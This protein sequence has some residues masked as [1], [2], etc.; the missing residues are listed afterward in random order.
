MIINN[1]FRYVLPIVCLLFWEYLIWG[2]LEIYSANQQELNFSYLSFLEP[3]IVVFLLMTGCS[4]FILYRLND[5]VSYIICYILL[6]FSIMSYIQAMFLNLKLVEDNGGTIHWEEYELY[7]YSNMVIWVIGIILLFAIFRM[8]ETTI[9]K[10][11]TSFIALFCL[12]VQIVTVV[13]I[14]FTGLRFNTV[15][16]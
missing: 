9:M 8:L 2:P 5:K 11:I 15:P 16:F 7:S 6:C 12:L 3:L 1:K 4:I 14:F 13:F 10:G